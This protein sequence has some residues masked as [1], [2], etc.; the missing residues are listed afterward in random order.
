MIALYI[1]SDIT[2]EMLRF[3]EADLQFREGASWVEEGAECAE[4]LSNS[5]KM[6]AGRL[7]L[8][9]SMRVC[10]RYISSMKAQ[11]MV[12]GCWDSRHAT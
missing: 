5:S 10:G 1:I 11:E 2:S 6:P 3:R 7:E 8:S 12:R 9:A 4:S